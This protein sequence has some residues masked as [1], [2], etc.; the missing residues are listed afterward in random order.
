ML[1]DNQKRFACRLAFLV[2][3]VLPTATTVYYILHPQTAT[4]WQQQI[5]SQL[6]VLTQI[7][8]VETPGPF[9]TILRGVRFYDADSNLILDATEAR[10]LFGDVNQVLLDHPVAMTSNGLHHITGQLNQHLVRSH[11]IA[12]PWQVFV[13]SAAVASNL[14]SDDHFGTQM[15]RELRLANAVITIESSPGGTVAQAEFSL[16]ETDSPTP[17]GEP[18]RIRCAL[19]RGRTNSLE[20]AS[21]LIELD[22]GDDALPC[23][24]AHAWLPK[25]NETMGHEV[26]FTG[27]VQLDVAST[28]SGQAEG[29]FLAVDL[30]EVTQPGVSLPARWGS[31]ELQQFMFQGNEVQHL[32][33]LN[34]PG[35]TRTRIDMPLEAYQRINVAQALRNATLQ[36]GEQRNT[37]KLLR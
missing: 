10:V 24:L 12:K 21:Q 34:M 20:P 23:W 19:R 6:G 17:A 8:S 13:R 7:D 33:F 31:I 29:N 5:Q 27:R 9:E 26:A 15:A 16:I 14:V 1:S 30:E 4:D 35:A 18:N 3:C 22:T 28:F 2:L 37:N 32:A 25:L 11:R 36:S